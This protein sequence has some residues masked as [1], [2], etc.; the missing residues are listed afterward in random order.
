M[1]LPP[2]SEIQKVPYEVLCGWGS[3]FNVINAYLVKHHRKFYFELPLYQA[4]ILGRNIKYQVLIGPTVRTIEAIANGRR[5]VNHS[6]VGH[7]GVQCWDVHPSRQG[8]LSVETWGFVVPTTLAYRNLM[9]NNGK[10]RLKSSPAGIAYEKIM[11]C[12]CPQCNLG[13]LRQQVKEFHSLDEES[14]E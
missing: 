14:S 12:L 4:E 11:D 5:G 9:E 13:W 2:Q 6:V 1:E 8:L 10:A 3:Y 7:Y